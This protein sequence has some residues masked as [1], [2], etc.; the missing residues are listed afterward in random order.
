M[1]LLMESKL[2]V[3]LRTFRVYVA[4]MCIK[5]FYQNFYHYSLE[6]FSIEFVKSRV[7]SIELQA[8]FMIAYCFKPIKML[9]KFLSLHKHQ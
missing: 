1:H 5:Q 7:M 2:I 9:L 6:L 8:Y 3:F 4:S